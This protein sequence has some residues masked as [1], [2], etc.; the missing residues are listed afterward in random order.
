M[1]M[2]KYRAWEDE[3][4]KTK[5]FSLVKILSQKNFCFYCFCFFFFLFLQNSHFVMRNSQLL[6]CIF[7][8]GLRGVADTE[9]IA[10]CEGSVAAW[11]RG[12]F[13]LVAVWVVVW[14][15]PVGLV[16]FQSRASAAQPSLYIGAQMALD[17]DQQEGCVALVA[18]GC[19]N[20][21]PWRFYTPLL[22]W[23]SVTDTM[24]LVSIM[25]LLLHIHIIP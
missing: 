9:S 19:A 8:I 16:A 3:W 22:M 11:R 5:K 2:E 10:W 12:C 20:P 14:P 15:L 4:L 18:F 23:F 13:L 1:L 7:C 17:H 25:Y 6:N 21:H 24:L